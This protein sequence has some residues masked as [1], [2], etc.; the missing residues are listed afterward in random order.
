MYV[1]ETDHFKIYSDFLESF[2]E[3]RQHRHFLELWMRA[4]EN[5]N[6]LALIVTRT[7]AIVVSFYLFS[8]N[9]GLQLLST[10][11]LLIP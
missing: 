6:T 9:K 1:E 3:L 4:K 2:H 7:T 8:T 5:R 10:V 11:Y